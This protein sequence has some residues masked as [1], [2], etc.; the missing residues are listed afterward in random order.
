MECLLYLFCSLETMD[1]KRSMR[2]C[3]LLFVR[4]TIVIMLIS[5]LD[6]S[7]GHIFYLLAYGYLWPDNHDAL[8]GL[9]ITSVQKNC[10]L[11]L[12]YLM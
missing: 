1:L 11:S 12:Q 9:D 4:Q 3:L 6:M 10:L 5:D 8:I 2:T 7:K